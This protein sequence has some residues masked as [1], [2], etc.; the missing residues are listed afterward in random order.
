MALYDIALHCI[1]LRCIASHDHPFHSMDLLHCLLAQ[2]RVYRLLARR[3]FEG[4]MFDR[5]SR[6][7]G[8]EVCL[9]AEVL[10]LL[11]RQ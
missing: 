3:A 2:V 8:L 1:A 9:C 10:A 7:L 11:H 6:K 4:T 5:A